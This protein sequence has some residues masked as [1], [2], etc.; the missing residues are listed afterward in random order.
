MTSNHKLKVKIVATIKISQHMK[1]LISCTE[2]KFSELSTTENDLE[3]TLIDS[4]DINQT[5][6][7]YCKEELTECAE[8]FSM[9]SVPVTLIGLD[10]RKTKH[11]NLITL[12]TIFDN[13]FNYFLEAT[14]S[15]MEKHRSK[16]EG[17][18]LLNNGF[19]PL[20]EIDAMED[21]PYVV[22]KLAQNLVLP[23]DLYVNEILLFEYATNRG[24]KQHSV[25]ARFS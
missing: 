8:Y 7:K 18:V 16:K 17:I 3:I 9:E 23:L 11:K 13:D 24:W 25:I 19:L 6:L 15:I 20:L 22:D 4:V 21:I 5:E 14:Q 1:S 12:K 2:K 10:C